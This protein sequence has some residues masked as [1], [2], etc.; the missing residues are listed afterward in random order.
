[1]KP[2]DEWN[3]PEDDQS[4][5]WTDEWQAGE[6]QVDKDIADGNYETYDTIEEFIKGLDDD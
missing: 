2:V 4:W 3:T 5:F 6:R 1:M